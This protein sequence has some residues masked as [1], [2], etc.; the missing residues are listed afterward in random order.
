MSNFGYWKFN[1]TNG[2]I[3]SAST[4]EELPDGRRVLVKNPDNPAVLEDQFIL[5]AIQK[6][7]QARADFDRL[8]PELDADSQDR[9]ATLL[10]NNPRASKLLTP[11]QVFMDRVQHDQVTSNVRT[12]IPSSTR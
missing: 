3:G 4:Y 8:F 6:S 1:N 12:R 9:L 2:L 11:D 7:R 10:E 5:N